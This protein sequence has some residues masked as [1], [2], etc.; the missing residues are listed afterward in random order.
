MN[1]MSVATALAAALALAAPVHAER[2]HRGNNM[3][4]VGLNGNRAQLAATDLSI[5][6]F[7]VGEPG[8]VVVYSR[9]LSDEWTVA[10]SGGFNASNE[11]TE[12]DSLEEFQFRTSSWNVRVGGDRYAWIDDN[13]ALYAGPGL[14][15]W[16]G[17][18]TEEFA[19]L[20][21][22]GPD[23]TQ[24]ALNGRIG[25]YAGFGGHLALFGH[26][27]QV[28]GLNT[29]DADDGQKTWWSSHHEGSVGLSYAF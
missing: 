21:T 5:G 19:G 12:P 13:V 17:K 11:R 8:L 3:L 14:I 1:R 10:L 16:K 29:A 15:V 28:I 23:V 25:M 18:S 2:L 27:G 24:L 22:D 26:I 7:E 9:F 4:W 6:A 20:E